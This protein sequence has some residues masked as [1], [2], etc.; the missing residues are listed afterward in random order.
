MPGSDSKM[1]ASGSS[2]DDA[3]IGL[4]GRV[5]VVHRSSLRELPHQPVEVAAHVIELPVD[6]HETFDDDL[7]MRVEQPRHDHAGDRAIATIVVCTIM[8]SYAPG[9]SSR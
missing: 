2:F 9:G 3:G 8:C 5:R 4:R 1:A 6:Q 7:P